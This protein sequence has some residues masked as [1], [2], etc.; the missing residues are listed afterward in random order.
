MAIKPPKLKENANIRIVA[1][2]SPPDLK[3]LSTSI[4]LLKKYGFNVSLGENIRKLV[5]R[6]DLAAPDKNRADELNQA[7]KD[8]TVDA[9][10]RI[11]Y[12]RLNVESSSSLLPVKLHSLIAYFRD[13]QTVS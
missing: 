9:V 2:A 4:N 13:R 3:V 1:P 7:F 12:K 5:Q 8:P 11:I 10:M 6:A